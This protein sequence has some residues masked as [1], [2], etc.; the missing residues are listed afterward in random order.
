MTTDRRSQPKAG[1][2]P[3]TFAMSRRTT[4]SA[5]FSGD[6]RYGTRT[7][8]RSATSHETVTV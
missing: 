5:K 1:Q 8:T 7:A 3:T 2:S 6:Y 4:F